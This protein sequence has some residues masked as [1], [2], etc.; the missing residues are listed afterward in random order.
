MSSSSSSFFFF[1][2][3]ST[4]LF[5]FKYTALV[6]HNR[7]CPID[8]QICIAAKRQ[9]ERFRKNNN[10]LITFLSS[11]FCRAYKTDPSTQHDIQVEFLL[12]WKY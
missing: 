10:I 1:Y 4:A 8:V 5:R 11:V 2:L 3:K 7:L 9:A 6:L 12:L